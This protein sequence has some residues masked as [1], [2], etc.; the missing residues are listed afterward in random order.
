MHTIATGGLVA[1]PVA[2]RPPQQGRGVAAGFGGGAAATLAD[3]VRADSLKTIAF[4]TGGVSSHSNDALRGLTEAEASSR[5]YYI[6]GYAPEGPP[7]GRSH[8]VQVRVRRITAELRWR[9]GFTRLLPE[10]ARAR[11]VQAAYLLPE[12]YAAGGVEV[13]LVP[14]PAEGPGR[15]ADLVLYVPPGR[16]LFLPEEGRPAARLEVGLTVLDG[17]AR[18]TLRLARSL[19][20]AWPGREPGQPGVGL[21]LV[22]RL[23]L[24]DA[25]Q[26]VTAV[27][28]DLASRSLWSARLQVPAVRAG[29][30][31]ISGLSIYSRSENSLWVEIEA[32]GEAPAETEEVVYATV[33]PALKATFSLG[34]PLLCGFR[35]PRGGKETLLRLVLHSGE[36]LIGELRIDP[37]MATDEG[38]LKHPLPIEDLPGGDYRLVVQELGPAPPI[39]RG[40]FSFQVAAPRPATPHPGP[41]AP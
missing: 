32:P 29:D 31:P 41:G 35:L 37:A 40:G 14:G 23:R 36:R 28:G 18:E 26:S 15:I 24:P 4:N 27:V 3:S 38:V 20:I 11:D 21:N 13:V 5:A 33:G 19:R 17:S 25:A 2:G 1:D 6:L 10:E 8:T 16:V 34:E 7:D 30:D 39:E 22:H 9:R 12:L